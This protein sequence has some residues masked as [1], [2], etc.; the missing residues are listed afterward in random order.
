MEAAK[1]KTIS[2]SNGHTLEIFDI[3]RKIGEARWNV[4]IL[5]GI[6]FELEAVFKRHPVEP[7]MQAD[8]KETLGN[9]VRFEQERERIF[10]EEKDKDDV[11]NSI[12][13]SFLNTNLIYFSHPDFSIRYVQKRYADRKKQASWRRTRE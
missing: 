6:D 10:I 9:S 12:I 1:I 7:A 4:G 2:L 13:D 8:I 3:S 11:L 5:G